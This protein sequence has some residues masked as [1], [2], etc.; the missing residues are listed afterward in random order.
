M[1]SNT[2]IVKHSSLVRFALTIFAVVIP[3]SEDFFLNGME[4]FVLFEFGLWDELFDLFLDKTLWVLKT[5]VYTKFNTALSS[6][7]IDTNLHA[8]RPRTT[9]VKTVYLVDKKICK[10][11]SWFRN[12]FR[13][14]LKI[15]FIRNINNTEM[16]IFGSMRLRHF[17]MWNE[18]HGFSLLV[19][20]KYAA[21]TGEAKRHFFTIKK[22]FN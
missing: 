3:A 18:C 6:S 5:I 17:V 15:L 12:A 10:V 2:Q 22:R 4:I 8:C 9:N 19:L 14:I 13:K 20:C 7:N 1:C 21:N 11:S 16:K